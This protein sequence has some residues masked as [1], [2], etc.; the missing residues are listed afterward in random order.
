MCP[1]LPFCLN[2]FGRHIRNSLEGDL[3]T[4]VLVAHHH[5]DVRKP[6]CRAPTVESVHE[7]IT[8]NDVRV[9]QSCYLEKG[10]C[11]CRYPDVSFNRIAQLTPIVMSLQEPSR[12]DRKPRAHADMRNKY[13]PVPS[14]TPTC[15]PGNIWLTQDQLMTATLIYTLQ[16]DVPKHESWLKMAL[17]AP[18]RFFRSMAHDP[19]TMQLI[20]DSGAS[21]SI[22]PNKDDFIGSLNDVPSTIKLN[23]L[24]KGLEI[25][26]AGTIEWN[27]LDTT[28]HLCTLKLP[29]Y[30]VP[31]S[32]VHLLSTT[33]LLQ[34]Y[35]DETILI[36]PH[37]LS[38]SGTQSDSARPPVSVRINLT[39]NLLTCPVHCPQDAHKA[40]EALSM[41]LSVVSDSNINLTEP[42]KEL[43]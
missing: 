35:A 19:S 3:G 23:G 2:E 30:Y 40:I 39:N 24:A 43:L 17:S 20:W 8:M 36:Q 6:K 9:C 34:T 26:G 41:T 10:N 25:A 5:H 11:K 28:G 37:E 16:F 15:G 12:S 27:V 4:P 21:I 32:P 1:D 33:S 38:L 22:T 13:R 42:Q 7:F 14:S 18:L 31:T 29:A